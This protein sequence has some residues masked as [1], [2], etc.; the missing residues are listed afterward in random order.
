MSQITCTKISY[1]G[2]LKI[3]VLIRNTSFNQSDNNDYFQK[4]KM[5]FRY[6]LEMIHL[7]ML[8][9]DIPIVDSS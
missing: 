6:S 1:D 3:Q 8:N 7:E 9:I 5:S 2:L 4:K